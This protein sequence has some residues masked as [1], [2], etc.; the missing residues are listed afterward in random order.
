[1]IGQSFFPEDLDCGNFFDNMDD[2]LDFPGSDIDVGF[3][4]GESDSFPNIWTTHHDTWP[5]A[6]DPLFSSNTNTNSETSPELYV[7][8]E[9]IVKVERPPSLVEKKEDSFSTNMDSSSSYSTFRS[10]SPVSVL[11]SSSSSSQTTNTTS[12]VLPGKQGRPRTKRPRPHLHEKDGVKDIVDSCLIVRIPK[13]FVSDHSKMITKKKKKKAKVTSSSS[14]SGIDLEVNGNSNVDSYSSD[15]NPVRKCMHCKVTKTP[16]WRLGPKGPKTLCNACGVR[17]KSGRLFPEYR[18]AA[19]PTFIPALHSNSHKKV[20]EMRSKRCKDGSYT[21]E[22]NDMQDLI[23]N[24]AYTGVDS[25][26]ER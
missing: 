24:N 25:N 7:P 5:P 10:S 23:P 17:Y 22:E 15:Q 20:A 11:E 6:S 19:S 2:I 14:S 8:F 13:Q 4:I 3:D 21:T 1:M 9:D 16:Q 26:R 12:L 18:P